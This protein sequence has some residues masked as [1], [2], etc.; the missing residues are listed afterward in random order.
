MET[1]ENNGD[2]YSLFSSNERF[3]LP[4]HNECDPNVVLC[5]AHAQ[6]NISDQYKKLRVSHSSDS[7]TT[8]FPEESNGE[9][10]SSKPMISY[11]NFI[12]YLSFFFFVHAGDLRC[13]LGNRRKS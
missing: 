8:G 3:R 7:T 13:N 11:L 2:T 5:Y 9:I 6:L 10:R 1:H 4:F 12:F